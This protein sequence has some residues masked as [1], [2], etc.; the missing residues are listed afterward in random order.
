MLKIAL[1]AGHGL[2]TKG[3]QTPNGIKE[4]TLNDLI[5][6]K[7]TAILKDYDCEIIRLDNNEGTVDEGLTTRL[8]TAISKGAKVLVSVHHNAYKG[9]FG[10]HSGVEVHT[11]KNPTKD[12]KKLANLVYNNLVDKTGL[13]GRGVKNSNFTVIN[14]SKITAILCEGG[15]MDS[16]IDYKIITSPSGQQAYA[17]AI[18]EAL[19]EMYGLKKKSKEK[20]KEKE[21]KI[22]VTYQ[23]YANENKKWLP[24]VVDLEDFAGIYG[25]T[26]GAVYAKLNKGNIYYKVH[27]K[28]GQWLPEVKNRTDYAGIYGMKID[29]I[30]IKT[31]TGKKVKYAVHLKKQNKWLPFVTG[32]NTKD[33]T[34]G[35]AGTLGQEIDG[36]RIYI[37][38][39]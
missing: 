19:I 4:W 18:A 29:G 5:C 25:K 17:E 8:N 16:S 22:S 10:T 37:E 11:D 36:I 20:T 35:Y 14:T 23:V 30:S 28:N 34:N 2:K 3:K 12:D 32:Y 15:F 6:D 9:V 7:A 38:E 27:L 26:I 31:D 24:N 1:D 39:K 21:S 13:K 33:K